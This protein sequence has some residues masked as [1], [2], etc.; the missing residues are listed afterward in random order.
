V[1]FSPRSRPEGTPSRPLL[2]RNDLENPVKSLNLPLHRLSSLYRECGA[3]AASH[4]SAW[5]SS[6]SRGAH[7]LPPNL[8]THSQIKY[9]QH[10]LAVACPTV[11]DTMSKPLTAGQVQIPMYEL[12][13]RHTLT[14]YLHLRRS[15]QS[16]FAHGLCPFC[17]SWAPA[18]SSV[19]SSAFPSSG[20]S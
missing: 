18:T 12:L 9:P 19:P 20:N 16:A 10:Q 14:S 13:I 7:S 8:S 5:I 11:S 15:M 3:A 6:P 4:C 2:S 17:L 1:T